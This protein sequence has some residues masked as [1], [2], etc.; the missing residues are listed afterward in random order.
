MSEV[1]R[2]TTKNIPNNATATYHMLVKKLLRYN[3][4]YKAQASGVN[5]RVTTPS[6]SKQVTYNHVMWRQLTRH[7]T[8]KFQTGDMRSSH[9]M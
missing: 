7:H 1:I 4:V 9:A 3:A 6:S 8:V 2:L 5:S